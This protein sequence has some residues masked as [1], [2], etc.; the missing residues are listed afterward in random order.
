MTDSGVFSR[1][2]IDRGS[3]ALLAALPETI[4]GDVLDMGCGYG[5]IGVSLKK[6]YPDARLTMVDINTRAAALA[7]Q[8]ARQN[9]VD[10][11]VLQ[12]D[13]FATVAGK[14]FDLIVTNP[15]IRAGKTG[16]VP[17]VLPMLPTPLQT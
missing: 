5:A 13:G 11:V 7:E 3:E 10:A 17:A 14:T 16:G 9:G 15:P 8:N 4:A 1:T 12:G 2:E 6:K